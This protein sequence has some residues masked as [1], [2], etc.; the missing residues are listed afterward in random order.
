MHFLQ[1]LQI[2][3]FWQVS[4]WQLLSS[5]HANL[6]SLHLDIAQ[7]NAAVWH[8]CSAPCLAG[9]R[10]CVLL[11][12]YVKASTS[13]SALQ[14]VQ[15]ILSPDMGWLPHPHPWPHS[16]RCHTSLTSQAQHTP[17]PG[18]GKRHR[19]PWLPIATLVC[20]QLHL[21]LQLTLQWP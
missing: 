19:R 4:F 9:C 2:P 5:V 17:M 1:L 10:C 11:E 21:H 12:S 15:V 20:L 6:L 7:L 13:L 14:I 3:S 18:T 8:S 16:P